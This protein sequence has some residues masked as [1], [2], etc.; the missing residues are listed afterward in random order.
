VAFNILNAKGP[1][2]FSLQSDPISMKFLDTSCIGRHFK[3]FSRAILVLAWSA[4]L[5]ACSVQTPIPD[6]PRDAPD[7]WHDH[8]ANAHAPESMQ[9]D[10]QNWWYAF[11]DT[12]L[13]ELIERALRD[14]LSI[15]MA[16]E[17]LRAARSL[18]RR[19]RSEFWPNLNFR[20]YEE[21]APGGA[22]G[23][24]E[25]GFDSTW[26]F[27]FFGR[28]QASSRM[29][30][31]DMNNAIIDEAGARVSIIAEVAKNYVELRAAQARANI[32]DDLVAV[33]RRQIELNE[34]LFHARLASLLD[35]NHAHKELEQAISEASEPRG[36]IFQTEQA[37]AVLLGTT[38]PEPSLRV[39]VAV[40]RLPAL[41]ISQT[42]AEL[43][44]T[45]P[46][47][48]HAE[49]NVLHA[50]GELGIAR[51][52]LY[53]KLGIG[54]SLI[55][56]TSVTGDVDRPNKAV[57]LI[58]PM[59]TIPIVD[60]GARREVVTA[61]EAALSAAVL[62]YREAV[63]EC[64]AEAQ[65]ALAQF[66]EK[67]A[68]VDNAQTGMMLSERSAQSAQTLQL[69]GLGDGFDSSNANIVLDQSRLQQTATLRERAL[70]YIALYKAF[71]GA[72]PPLKS[73]P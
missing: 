40:P 6:L 45:R 50:A 18:R 52:D 20:I 3:L 27:G 4:L 66:D 10:L 69:I 68:L 61:R 43:L 53:P 22:T 54:G 63:L 31:A 29:S 17:R 64:V 42:P 62:A 24:F 28:S 8:N 23:Y 67:S 7:A 48:R 9:P 14:N 65:T 46:E 56:A 44:R 1:T 41:D 21:T 2:S 16:G 37:L 15:Q 49:Q 33:R 39:I 59:V 47:I 60:W 11:D 55:S 12:T 73:P 34:A 13:N 71:G 26:E 36:T 5:G 35:V 30:L 70:S 32:L 19:A 57:P 51:A 58:G 25:M 38:N 72:I